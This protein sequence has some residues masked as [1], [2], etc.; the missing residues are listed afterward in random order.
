MKNSND[1]IGNRTRDL[2]ACSAVP[3]IT[4]PPR[5]PEWWHTFPEFNLLIFPCILFNFIVYF[6]TYSKLATFSKNQVAWSNDF[7]LH[8]SEEIWTCTNV[9][10]LGNGSRP[11]SLLFYFKKLCFLSLGFVSP[12]NIILSYPALGVLGSDPG[13]DNERRIGDLV[14]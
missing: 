12:S 4:A 13:G 9:R 5:A 8:S 6:L 7:L 11:V 1:T 2:P 14:V 3:Q 10:F